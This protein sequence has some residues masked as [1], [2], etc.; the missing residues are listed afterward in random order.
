MP[1]RNLGR[2]IDVLQVSDDFTEH[3][4]MAIAYENKTFTSYKRFSKGFVL[5]EECRTKSGGNIYVVNQINY[6]N[7][8]YGYAVL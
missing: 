4:E 1:E 6:Q 7:C 5:P 2:N 8:C 3:I